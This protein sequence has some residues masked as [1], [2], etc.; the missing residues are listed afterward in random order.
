MIDLSN[1]TYL[2]I[3]SDGTILEGK[4]LSYPGNHYIILEKMRELYPD[5]A[6][7]TFN[8]DFRDNKEQVKLYNDLIHQGAIV[9]QAWSTFN[10][11]NITDTDVYLPD[12]ITA[13]QKQILDS[14]ID[15]LDKMNIIPYELCDNDY[16]D[17]SPYK[18][19]EGFAYLQTYIE[20]HLIKK[21]KF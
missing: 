14:I 17:I 9:Y 10:G 21:N 11:E 18:I 20:E 5:F 4:K 3:L 19:S 2:I 13:E 8:Y 7:M 6:E 12:K 1:I 16:L 15:Q